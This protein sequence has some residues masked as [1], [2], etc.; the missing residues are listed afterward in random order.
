MSHSPNNPRFA[1]IQS[2][3][4]SKPVVIYMKGSP[5]FPACGFSARACEVLYAA[6]VK[7]EE[8]AHFDVLE[9]REM[10]QAL[11]EFNNWP[12]SPQIFIHGK[13]VGG[14]DIVMEMY[15]RGEL[16][17]MLKSESKS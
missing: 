2:F 14:S 3:I 6:G 10:F 7:K 5:Q 11:K 16:Q 4:Q 15:E 9:D 13:F 8:I 17:Q 1:Q 12:T